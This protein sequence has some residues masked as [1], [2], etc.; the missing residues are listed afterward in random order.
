MIPDVLIPES[1]ALTWI[2]E[3]FA[4]W[5]G[6]GVGLSLAFFMAGYGAYFVIDFMR[7]GVV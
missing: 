5:V 4:A 2:V 6:L 7:G 3:V 1:T